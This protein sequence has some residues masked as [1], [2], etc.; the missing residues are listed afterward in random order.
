MTKRQIRK[1]SDQQLDQ[2]L[3]DG[4]I[5]FKQWMDEGLDRSI[6]KKVL[7]SL[8]QEE[9]QALLDMFNKNKK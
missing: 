4:L 6:N 3:N 9:V 5:T 8:S 1:L 7:N 2:A